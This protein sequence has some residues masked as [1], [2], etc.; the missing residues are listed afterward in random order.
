MRPELPQ[1][2]AAV[3]LHAG[4]SLHAAA[5]REFLASHLAGFKVPSHIWFRDKQLPRI[6]TGK[7]FKRQLRSDYAAELAQRATTT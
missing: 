7:I 2:D 5:L 1:F 3:P 4:Q 6:A